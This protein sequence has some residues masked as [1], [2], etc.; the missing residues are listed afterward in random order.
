MSELDALLLN[1][2]HKLPQ[3]NVV[4]RPEQECDWTIKILLTNESTASGHS[5]DPGI[6]L[7]GRAR[8]SACILATPLFARNRNSDGPDW[9]GFSDDHS[10][11]RP[12][13]RWHSRPG[14]RAN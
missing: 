1:L 9:S 6:N 4:V 12:V 3:P 10:A 13:Y 7:D 14:S 5:R 11:D 8:L 2:H